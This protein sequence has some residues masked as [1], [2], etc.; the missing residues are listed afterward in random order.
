MIHPSESQGEL[1]EGHDGEPGLNLSFRQANGEGGTEAR[2][3]A[4]FRTFRGSQRYYSIRCKCKVRG[5]TGAV[6]QEAN[7]LGHKGPEGCAK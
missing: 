2:I 4:K 6:A 5:G 1:F 7:R 3:N